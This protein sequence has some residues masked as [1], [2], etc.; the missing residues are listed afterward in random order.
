M[1]IFSASF[2]TE[3]DA[4]LD[5][6]DK[7]FKSKLSTLAVYDTCILNYST[8]N[9]AIFE[10]FD[11]FFTKS[12]LFCIAFQLTKLHLLQ[13]PF[14]YCEKTACTLDHFQKVLLF[15]LFQLL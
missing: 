2:G 3:I 11:I 10:I 8:Y 5:N 4:S 15:Q 9:K 13:N 12:Y 1:L 7:I 6:S 14:F